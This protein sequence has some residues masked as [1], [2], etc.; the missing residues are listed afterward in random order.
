MI[1]TT[2]LQLPYIAAAQAQKHITHN[3]ALR[4]LDAIVQL[5]VINSNLI[6]P[7]ASP[8]DGDSYI[9]AANATGEWLNKDNQV[10]AWQD[11]VW[12]F[13]EPKEGWLAWNATDGQL[14]IYTNTSW[15]NALNTSFQNIAM[16]GINATADVINRL[17]VNSE[18]T[19]LN[20]DGNGHQLKVNKNTLGDN[21][22]ILFQTGFSGRAEFGLT[23]DDEWHVKMSGDGTNWVEAQVVTSEGYVKQPNN[24][25]AFNVRRSTDVT[26]TG[27]FTIT[28]YDETI[29]NVG[30][31]FNLATGLFTAPTA[32]VVF[33]QG[34]VSFEGGDGTDDS[35]YMHIRHN[36]TNQNIVYINP[37]AF[38]EVGKEAAFSVGGVYSLA[39]GDTLGLQ[40]SGIESTTSA[41]IIDCTFFGH[42]VGVQ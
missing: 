3:E 16:M 4:A 22:S 25:M 7:P 6:S 42:A 23:G 12:I 24:L 8:N 19:L 35:C 21:A 20:H 32:C 13:Y 40:I 1:S 37:R 11:N 38:T 30:S 27:E 2:K 29:A 34:N 33:V 5:S 39:Q 9:I 10:S 41:K 31:H 17:S 36:S 18:A 15:I 14:Y 28:S 26:T